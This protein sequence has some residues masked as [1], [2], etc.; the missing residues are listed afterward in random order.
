MTPLPWAGLYLGRSGHWDHWK[1]LPDLRGMHAMVHGS[2]SLCGQ[3]PTSSLP[4]D[5]LWPAST[6]S[7]NVGSVYGQTCSIL[8]GLTFVPLLKPLDLTQAG[9]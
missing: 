3:G 5:C 2:H 9:E 4:W 1:P 7:G 6:L 8:G